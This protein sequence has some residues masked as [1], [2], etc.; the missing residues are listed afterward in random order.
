MPKPSIGKDLLKIT[1]RIK[2]KGMPSKG[3]EMESEDTQEKPLE[4]DLASILRQAADLVDE[5]AYDE[6]MGLI[7]DA[8]E[9]C[10]EMCNS[11]ES[12]TAGMEE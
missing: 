8:S 7:D 5:G 12:G 6:A 3:S 10:G 2:P 11:E 1:Y 4:G 9:M